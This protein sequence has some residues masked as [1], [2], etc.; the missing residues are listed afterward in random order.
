[1]VIA[2]DKNLQN[3]LIIVDDIAIDPILDF[4]LYG[5]AISKIITKSYPKFTIGI[6]GDWGTGKTTLMCLIDKSC[7]TSNFL[8]GELIYIMS[9]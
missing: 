2:E 7:K 5:R 1:L 8:K 4:N 9:I 3:G 6:F